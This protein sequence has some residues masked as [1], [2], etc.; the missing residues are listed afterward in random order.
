MI[1]RVVVRY[2]ALPAAQKLQF[3]VVISLKKMVLDALPHCTI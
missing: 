1:R 2:Q 3:F